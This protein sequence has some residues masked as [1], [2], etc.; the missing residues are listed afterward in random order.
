MELS[1]YF[2]KMG[3]ELKIL[4]ADIGKIVNQKKSEEKQ[5][6]NGEEPKK[7]EV[8]LK[9]F[10][11]ITTLSKSKKEIEELKAEPPEM[12]FISNQINKIFK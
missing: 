5:K 3:N 8:F 10:Q 9:S 7:S 12:T 1:G 4:N 11:Q 2:N 6:K